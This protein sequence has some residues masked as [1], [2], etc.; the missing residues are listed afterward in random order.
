MKINIAIIAPKTGIGGGNRKYKLYFDNLSAKYF[1]KHYLSLGTD[2]NNVEDLIEFIKK[3][4]VDYVYIS[5]IIT[6]QEILILKKHTTILTNVNFSSNYVDDPDVLNLFISKTLYLKTNNK[7]QSNSYVV[8]NPID[9]KYWTRKY[10]KNDNSPLTIGR[11]ARAEPNKW[12]YLILKTLIE[13][14]RQKNYK[15][16]F[17]FVGLPKLYDFAIKFKLSKRMRQ[18]ISIQTEIKDTNKI[19]DFYNSI[20]I[21]WQA[22]AVGETFGN[23]IAEAFCFKKPV[24]TDSKDF[25]TN[26]NVD[27]SQ[28]E[29]VDDELNGLYANSSEVV[30]KSLEQ[31]SNREFR[32]KLG[33]NGYVKVKKYYDARIASDTLA[34]VLYDDLK[35]R[36]PLNQE[37]FEALKIIPSQKEIDN[38]KKEYL[39]KIQKIKKKNKTNKIPLFWKILETIY[40]L[41]RKILRALGINIEN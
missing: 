32:L 13:L 29:L 34:K 15:Y 11:I 20:D 1:N 18:N 6:K 2:F 4:K 41:L 40:L 22:S 27:N 28:I 24:I 38:Y 5:N 8:Y 19:A 33:N 3:N 30:I 14:D 12:D 37:E 21:Y 17:I 10:K 7:N 23:T 16:K 9:I 31:L 26:K 39:Q 35:R 36:K 25:L